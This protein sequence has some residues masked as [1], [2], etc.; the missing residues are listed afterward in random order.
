MNH[1][2]KALFVGPYP[3]PIDGHSFAFQTIYDNYTYPKYIINQ[4]FKNQKFKLLSAIT[5]L[6]SYFKFFLR[7]DIDVLYLAGSRSVF[8]SLKDIILI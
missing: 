4:N 5:I 7:K 2:K 3:P 6:F 1:T 8:G